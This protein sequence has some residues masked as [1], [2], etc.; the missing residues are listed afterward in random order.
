MPFD[1]GTAEL[2][3]QFFADILLGIHLVALGMSLWSQLYSNSVR[4]RRVH[5]FL[6]IATVAMGLI[7]MFNAALGVALNILAWDRKTV[8][9]YIDAPWPY[10]LI[11]VNI[12][13]QSLI[14]DATWI[15]RCWIVYERNWKA[16]IFSI[17][18]WISGLVVS[19]LVVVKAGPTH[20]FK[21]IN[22]PSLTPFIGSAL[23]LTVVLNIV[24]TTLIVLRIWRVS[25]G[26]RIYIV[27]QQ[28][29]TYVMRIIVES[30]LLY[31]LSA[32]LV[33]MTSVF[34]SNLD[35]IAGH[36]FVQ[37]IGISFNLVIVRFDHNLADQRTYPSQASHIP[38]P[39]STFPASRPSAV[40]SAPMV[41]IR[42][43]QDMVVDKGSL[44]DRVH[45][46]EPGAV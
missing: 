26:I 13:V 3:A 8:M 40:H 37:M 35:Y 33:L 34:K 7:G 17:F 38:V 20:R 28:R 46:F 30:G 31:T 25:R 36:C 10:K 42:V 19:T 11:N 29:L 32:I 18:L 43:S 22:D 4:G 9:V 14:G 6:V 21:G 23:V 45:E 12:V 1:P 39:L 16:I 41:H 5:S 2:L 27:G 15:Y 44:P 24:T